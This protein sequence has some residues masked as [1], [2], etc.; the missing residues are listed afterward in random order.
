MRLDQIIL[1][2][3]KEVE[4]LRA[5]NQALED[6]LRAVECRLPVPVALLTAKAA[7]E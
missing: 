4:D 2:L 6:R 5:L 1:R 7:G 3:C